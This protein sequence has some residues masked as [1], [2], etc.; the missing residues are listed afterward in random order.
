MVIFLY[1]NPTH[2]LITLE[3][4]SESHKKW[5]LPV[6]FWRDLQHCLLSWGMGQR[7]RDTQVKIWFRAKEHD[8]G[9]DMLGEEMF[10]EGHIKKKN[11]QCVLVWKQSTRQTFVYN[12]FSEETLPR[13][14]KGVERVGKGRERGWIGTHVRQSSGAESATASFLCQKAIWVVTDAIRET[15]TPWNWRF[16]VAVKYLLLNYHLLQKKPWAEQ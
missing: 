16:L 9:M 15:F 12:Q 13:E 1:L 4:N 5:P 8:L 10:V 11:P 3:N 7:E 14:T 6:I 2:V